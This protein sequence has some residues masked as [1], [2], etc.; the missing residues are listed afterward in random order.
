M[1]VI[2]AFVVAGLQTRA[3]AGPISHPASTASS[4]QLR[5]IRRKVLA[6]AALLAV[7]FTTPSLH[8]APV[9]DDAKPT[10]AISATRSTSPMLAA[11]AAAKGDA[12]LEALLTELERS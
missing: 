3:F 12:L 9:T 5:T 4:H 10:A 7:S 2:P 6:T 8:A 1:S 11:N